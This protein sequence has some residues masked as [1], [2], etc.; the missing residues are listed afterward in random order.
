MTLLTCLQNLLNAELELYI[1]GIGKEMLIHN[2]HQQNN[3][4]LVFDLCAQ[5]MEKEL[6]IAIDVVLRQHI[7]VGL[8][9]KTAH[10]DCEL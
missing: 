1:Y 2:F 7:N 6:F 4:L 9:I 3:L 8:T 10:V 5:S